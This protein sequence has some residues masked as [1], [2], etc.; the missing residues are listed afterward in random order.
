[1]ASQPVEA[2][3]FDMGGVVLEICFDNVFQAMTRFSTLPMPEIRAR[4]SMDDAYQQHEKGMI[5]GSEYVDHLRR[6]LQLEASDADII[7]AWN[8]VFGDEISPVLDAIGHISARYPCDGFTNTNK[9]HQQ[10]W[11]NEHPRIRKTFRNLFVSSEIGLRKPDADAFEYISQYTGIELQNILFFDDTLE[12]IDGAKR[13]GL[14]TVLVE[15]P[16]SVIHALNE[17]P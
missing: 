4:F 13:V 5:S 12:N 9:I 6:Q 3:L 2:L 14:Q 15:G 16:H 11:D 1:M 7:E 17:L 8:A 10:Y